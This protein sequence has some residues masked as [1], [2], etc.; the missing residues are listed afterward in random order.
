M[1]TEVLAPGAVPLH[2]GTWRARRTS[3][4]LPG[5]PACI[6]GAGGNGPTF[7][8]SPGPVT[9]TLKPGLEQALCVSVTLMGP[10]HRRLP[11][12]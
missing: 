5:R 11:G 4:L 3:S 10:R 6:T 7:S 8:P 12:G 2:L 9:N 1:Q